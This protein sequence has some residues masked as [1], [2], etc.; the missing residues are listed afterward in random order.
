MNQENEYNLGCLSIVR[1]NEYWISKP[2][3]SRVKTLKVIVIVG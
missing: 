1:Y 3:N 2:M